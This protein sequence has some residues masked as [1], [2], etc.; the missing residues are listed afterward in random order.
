[1]DWGVIEEGSFPANRSEHFICI[2]IV[3]STGYCFSV[4]QIRNRNAALAQTVYKVHGSVDR[5]DHKGFV[6]G[7]RIRVFCLLTKKTRRGEGSRQESGQLFL[8]FQVIL[9]HH[10]SCRALVS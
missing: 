8:Y 5:I 2:G 6:C 1:M 4:P 10:V 3:D 7:K 9:G